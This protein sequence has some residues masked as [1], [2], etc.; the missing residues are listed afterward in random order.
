[1]QSLAV[2]DHAALPYTQ[3]YCFHGTPITVRSDLP[4]VMEAVDNRLRHFRSPQPLAGAR[5]IVFR[6]AA[7]LS[8]VQ[9]PAETEVIMLRPK[10]RLEFA[11]GDGLLYYTLHDRLIMRSSSD[12]GWA[13]AW[14]LPPEEAAVWHSAHQ[15]LLSAL[16]DLVRP[17]RM[18]AV[19]AA[20]MTHHGKCAM[21][22]GVSGAG[23]STLSVILL[24]AGFG[25][26]ADDTAFLSADGE[27]I[28]IKA[29]PDDIDLTD[30][31]LELFPDLRAHLRPSRSSWKH[32]V[33]PEDLAPEGLV[34]SSV[35]DVLLFPHVANTDRSVIS[36]MGST[37]AFS[38]LFKQVLIANQRSANEHFH[39]LARLVDQV[40]CY[41][42][43]TGRDF[44]ELPGMIADLL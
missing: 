7:D 31:S 40:R 41:R 37:E 8:A 27:R 34:E 9:P 4:L 19:H 42:I 21:L 16:S 44:D 10:Q 1:M 32:Q 23:K 43:E 38:K 35:P 3:D 15:A 29:F 6:A 33:W 30:N 12:E 11:P 5:S 18:F 36:E 20:A 28:E 17:S 22:S 2:E 13:E 26:L 39:V 25:F 24:K 14:V